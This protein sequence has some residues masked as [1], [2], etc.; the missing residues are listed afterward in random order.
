MG[1]WK[2]ALNTSRVRLFDWPPPRF[3]VRGR[4]ARQRRG[5]RRARAGG[6]VGASRARRKSFR[7]RRFSRRAVLVSPVGDGEKRERGSRPSSRACVGVERSRARSIARTRPRLALDADPIGARARARRVRACRVAHLG[8]V[9]DP[10]SS[11]PPRNGEARPIPFL[12]PVIPSPVALARAFASDAARI[13]E[14]TGAPGRPLERRVSSRRSAA[15]RASRGT[16]TCARGLRFSLV[17]SAE[18]ADADRA[19]RAREHCAFSQPLPT[20]LL[21]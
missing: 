7:Q 14:R 6:G 5:R 8:H 11:S 9:P 3:C 18:G 4:E 2:L 19:A 16:V 21:V 15:P 1:R 20:A 13:P 17:A 10:R 12:P